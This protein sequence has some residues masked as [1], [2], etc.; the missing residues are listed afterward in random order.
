MAF[1]SGGNRKKGGWIVI[2]GRRGFGE[3]VDEYKA[4]IIVLSVVLL[5]A[6]LTAYLYFAGPLAVSR[7]KE[8]GLSAINAG[9]Y[10]LAATSLEK[11]NGFSNSKRIDIL[12]PL[13]VVYFAEERYAD[14][15]G[16]FNALINLFGGEVPYRDASANDNAG[17]AH[18]NGLSTERGTLFEF[19]EKP[20]VP[21]DAFMDAPGLPRVCYMLAEAYAYIGE[22]DSAYDAAYYGFV[23]TG[24][25]DLLTL[26][27]TVRVDAP[28]SLTVSGVYNGR[29]IFRFEQTAEGVRTF[30]RQGDPPF[31]REAIANAGFFM[32]AVEYRINEGIEIDIGEHVIHAI[33]INRYGQ[34]SEDAEYR[35]TVLD[36]AGNLNGNIINGAIAAERGDEVFFFNGAGIYKESHEVSAP[37]SPTAASNPSGVDSTAANQ[38]AANQTAASQNAA[39]P[40]D[41]ATGMRLP[42]VTKLIEGNDIKCLNLLGEWLYFTRTGGIYTGIFKIRIDGTGLSRV[43]ETG[44]EYLQTMGDKLYFT[45]RE[46][47]C[48]MPPDG[49]EIT[50]LV[51]GNILCVNYGDGKLYFINELPNGN[52]DDA[53]P[54]YCYDIYSGDLI[55][56]I[57]EPVSFFQVYN[58]RIYYFQY[59]SSNGNTAI[60]PGADAGAGLFNVFVTDLDGGQSGRLMLPTGAVEAGAGAETANSTLIV[61]PGV[62]AQ[63]TN[64]GFI[65][66]GDII[67]YYDSVGRRLCSIS[68]ADAARG[69]DGTTRETALARMDQCGAINIAAGYIYGF[70]PGEET[71]QGYFR[72]PAGQSGIA[73]DSDGQTQY[74]EDISSLDYNGSVHRYGDKLYLVDRDANGEQNIYPI[75]TDDN[76]NDP[77]TAALLALLPTDPSGIPGEIPPGSPTGWQEPAR[78]G[79][80]GESALRSHANESEF[81]KPIYETAREKSQYESAFNGISPVGEAMLSGIPADE[82][83]VY[84]NEYFVITSDYINARIYTLPDNGAGSAQNVNS[85][86]GANNAPDESATSNVNSVYNVNF[87]YGA[88]VYGSALHNYLLDMQTN[89]E[90][91][92]NAENAGANPDSG[93]DENNGDDT[94]RTDDNTE[95]GTDAAA[96]AGVETGGETTDVEAGE[97]NSGDAGLADETNGG[98]GVDEESAR[99]IEN[100]V[101]PET[102]TDNGMHMWHGLSRFGQFDD[103]LYFT[104]QAGFFSSDLEFTTATFICADGPEIGEEFIVYGN[105]VAFKKSAVSGESGLYA[106]DLESG[107]QKRIFGGNAAGFDIYENKVVYTDAEDG[108]LYIQDIDSDTPAIGIF[109]E[110]ELPCDSV[111]F[112]DNGG[113]TVRSPEN[114]YAVYAIELSEFSIQ[115]LT[116]S[117]VGIFAYYNG[118]IYYEAW[119]APGFF[120]RQDISH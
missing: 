56:L 88:I 54:V 4:L 29:F 72:L 57:D 87:V 103:R 106:L 36:A 112:N 5:S 42:S 92:D 115:R 14:S 18:N 35:F 67:Y 64:R 12:Y 20:D 86:T 96:S 91:A 1:G 90:I 101:A 76:A 10:D 105:N 110:G 77:A 49:G 108:G 30:Y 40:S 50:L 17:V 9:D 82:N 24:D 71:G 13:G 73:P 6:A 3:I 116:E 118:F 114:G 93:S 111:F 16:V 70:L 104:S 23:T 52:V 19:A 43:S 28:I 46:G 58:N 55:K 80:A 61:A 117:G 11:A 51:E 85:A 119:D 48:S 89:A 38:T 26:A 84:I 100:I 53:G 98:G 44:A 31:D 33:N 81:L 41:A 65:I 45:T 102:L 8:A 7:H 15:I 107:V 75:K 99:Q 69:S 95:T 113:I 21:L 120:L 32:D 25:I 60:N 74:L 63:D 94:P 34:V 27:E 37:G 62:V 97:A 2:S 22:G 39:H 78:Q 59:N 79:N 66:D 68:I 109:T 83:V 47:L